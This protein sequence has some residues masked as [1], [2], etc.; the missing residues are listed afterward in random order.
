MQKLLLVSGTCLI[1]AGLV[2]GT[3]LDWFASQSLA[4]DAHVA[5][6]QHGMLLIL[7]ALAWKHSELGKLSWSCSLLNIVGLYGIWAAFLIGA[8]IGDP[9][10]SASAITYFLFVTSSTLLIA[11]I[12]IFLLGLVRKKVTA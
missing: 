6:V 4:S 10:P 8:I 3:M 12:A 1:L 9:Y 2:L 7:I 11:G 5:G